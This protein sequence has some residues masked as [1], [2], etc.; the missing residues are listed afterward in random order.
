MA[1]WTGLYWYLKK[2]TK[3]G[4]CEER[5]EGVIEGQNRLGYSL[6][7]EA[8]LLIFKVSSEDSF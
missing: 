1:F 7:N 4:T 5:T 2:N 6:R 3:I 8:L